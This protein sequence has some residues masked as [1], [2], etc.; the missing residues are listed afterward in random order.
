MATVSGEERSILWT[1]SVI[2]GRSEEA[3]FVL[4]TGTD[5]SRLRSLEDDARR[6]EVAEAR[7]QAREEALRV[8]SQKYAGIIEIASEAIISIDPEH[9]IRMFNHGAEEVFGYSAE[10]VLGEP[11]E[12][13]LPPESRG[14]HRGHVETFGASPGPSRRMGE[15]RQ[16][17]GMRKGGE[18]FPAEASIL[19]L[20]VEG[21][22]LY[23]VVLRDVGERVRQEA[24]QNLLSEVGRELQRSLD[25]KTTLRNAVESTLGH[26]A[27]FSFIDV[28]EEDGSIRR[29]QALHRDPRQA[30]LAR[31]FLNRELDRSRP[32]LVG[33]VFLEDRSELVREV[34]PEVLDRLGQNPDHRTAL[35]QLDPGSFLSVPLK[36]RGRT[37]G[38]LFCARERGRPPLDEEDLALAEEL[39][40][41]AGTAVDNAR[42][43]RDAR[44]AIEAR[45]DV[46]SVV[47]HDLGNPLQAIFIGLEALERTRPGRAEGRGG[48]EE[49][50]LSAIRRSAD[51]MQRLIQDL[52]E[53]RRLEAGHL[54]LERHSVS[55]SPLIREA[56]QGMDPLARVKE[57]ALSAPQEDTDLPRVFADGDRIQQVLSNLLGNAVKHTPEGGR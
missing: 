41:R 17:A 31:N 27:D 1:Y 38:A 42:L 14:A 47:S 21:E 52:L 32:H 7:R 36:A 5:V 18:R 22:R 54:Q 30:E 8:T 51:T 6:R 55:V 24:R 49:Y 45:D 50:Y 20:D 46:L 43:Y 23:T 34:T 57:I 28:E 37:I 10:E 19:K 3:R 15:R 33:S 9:R 40:R 26:L 16:I 48:G 56:L 4:A 35:G 25:Y 2:R 53:V 12:L 13:L 39:G 11:L 44:R 29:L